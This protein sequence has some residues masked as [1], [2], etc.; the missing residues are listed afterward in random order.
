VKGVAY[1][2][3][4]QRSDFPSSDASDGR[5]SFQKAAAQARTKN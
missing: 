3:M 1:I 4:V 2:L 5:R